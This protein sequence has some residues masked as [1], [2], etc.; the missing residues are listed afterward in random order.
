[1]INAFIKCIKG[2]NCFTKDMKSFRNFSPDLEESSSS[3]EHA[4]DFAD[5]RRIFRRYI[6]IELIKISGF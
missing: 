6:M 4:A 3:D 5:R 2:N 1:M